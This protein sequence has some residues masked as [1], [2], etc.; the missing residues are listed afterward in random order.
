M[1]IINEDIDSKILFKKMLP[2]LRALNGPQNKLTY[3]LDTKG[4][5]YLILQAK[6]G[7]VVVGQ[8]FINDGNYSGNSLEIDSPTGIF[9]EKTFYKI[10][11]T[12]I[13]Q[14]LG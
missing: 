7:K 14:Y 5:R 1:N 6:L 10:A 13:E 2:G 3:H 4:D 11:R 9:E 12:L 8:L